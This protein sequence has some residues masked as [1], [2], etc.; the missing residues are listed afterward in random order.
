M[1]QQKYQKAI[2]FA[3]EKHANQNVP[4]TDANY[5]AHLS[6]VAMEIMV[7]YDNSNNFDLSF[8]VQLAFLHDILEDT[9]TTINEL[10]VQF[11]LKIALGVSALTKNEKLNTKQEQMLDSLSRIKQMPVEVGVVKLADRITNLQEPPKHWGNVKKAEYLEEA[12]LILKNLSDKNEY[13][14]QRLKTKIEEYSI[15]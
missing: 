12:K 7:A 4:G 6:C 10:E 9:E 1:L 11:D 2:R 5:L 3:G 15:L 14:S 13:L 8:A